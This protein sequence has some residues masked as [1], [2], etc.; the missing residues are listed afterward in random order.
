[1]V[2]AHLRAR[3]FR[4]LGDLTL[5]P[6]S[7]VCVLFGDNAQGKSNIVEAV[8]VLSNL[9]SFRTRRARDLIESGFPE[10][11]VEGEILGQNGTVR[12][13]IRL[14]GSGR[15]AR[16]DGKIPASISSYLSEFHTVLFSPADI[17]LARGSQDLRRRYLD[18]AAFWDDPG[19]LARLRDWNRV[20]RHRNACL[21]RGDDGIDVWDG[22]L[23]RLG[24]AVHQA[25]RRA[26]EALGPAVTA[27]HA[28]ISGGEEAGLACCASGAS[29]QGEE[30]LRDC[31]RRSR[32]RDAQLGY[33]TVG[34]HR[35][36]VRL[37]LG[38]RAAERFASQGQLRTLALSLKL[39]LLQ[40][41][42]ESLGEKPVFLLDDPG[43]ELDRKRLGF[44]GSFLE[45][46]SGQ[47]IV[48]GTD[49][50]ALPVPDPTAARYYR[51]AGGNARAA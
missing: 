1:M 16:V 42:G 13:Q 47:V 3:R 5:D 8:H 14:D 41:G 22:E 40:R 32:V 36:T 15:T 21:R 26:A 43:S 31:L 50:D 38:G 39:A 28:E 35:D 48:A 4:N 37:K 51:V 25:R 49:R 2:L 19:H 45:S 9:Q 7:R 11:F 44:L 30:A 24:A 29:D 27:L 12:L 20:M 33:T 10:A 18:R 34:P 46:W 17:E 23:A 6:G